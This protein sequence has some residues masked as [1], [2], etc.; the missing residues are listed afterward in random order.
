MKNK[1]IH[2][3]TI[4]CNTS[5]VDQ[6]TNA[7]SLF[8]VLEQLKIDIQLEKDVEV[9]NVPMQFQLVTLWE[10]LTQDNEEKAD[11]LMEYYDP[12]NK[13]LG[14]FNLNLTIPAD[15]KRFRLMTN[16]NGWSLTTSGTYTF[17][18]SKKEPGSASFE[19]VGE[20]TIDIIL[21]KEIKNLIK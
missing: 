13:K 11:I 15:K 6:T 20:V 14:S 16:I 19:N 4:P 7:V 10:K 21:N 2:R 18:I 9:L 12:S 5:S 17:K 3:W 8:G 1:I